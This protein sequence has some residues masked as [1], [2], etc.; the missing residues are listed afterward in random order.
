V[1]GS[2]VVFVLGATMPTIIGAPMEISEI[3]LEP[4]EVGN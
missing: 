2:K 1:G 4:G 3:E